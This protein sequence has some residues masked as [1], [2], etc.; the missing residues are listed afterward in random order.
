MVHVLGY[1]PPPVNPVDHTFDP[2]PGVLPV[3]VIVVVVCAAVAP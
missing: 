1:I 2:M 3:V